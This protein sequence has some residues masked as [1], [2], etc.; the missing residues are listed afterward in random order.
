[1]IKNRDW[2]KKMRLKKGLTQKELAEKTG[3]TIF[4]IQNIEQGS[5]KGSPA[6]WEKILAFF[7]NNGLTPKISH[8]SEELIEEL[9]EDIFEFGEDYE[10]YVFYKEKDGRLVFTNYDFDTEE[11]PIKPD[12]LLLDEHLLKTTLGDALKLFE[13][14]NE[15]L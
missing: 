10:C 9:K 7:E 6:T 12:E 13:K 11:D 15:I 14:Q 2:L 3:L 8:D 1:M 4:T 5:R